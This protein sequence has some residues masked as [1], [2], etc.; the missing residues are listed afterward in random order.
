[1]KAFRGNTIDSWEFC[2][3]DGDPTDHCASGGSNAF[4]DSCI[5]RVTRNTRNILKIA[6]DPQVGFQERSIPIYL[7]SDVPFEL[8]I[9]ICCA[10]NLWFFIL[11]HTPVLSTDQRVFFPFSRFPVSFYV[12]VSI[13]IYP[14][15]NWDKSRRFFRQ[16]STDQILMNPSVLESRR[17]ASSSVE[18]MHC[19]LAIDFTESRPI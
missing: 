5:S 2:Y 15:S 3:W 7:V 11:I 9:V 16:H 14:T 10:V 19:L 13:A 1:M 18:C 4:P 6:S 12:L 8:S 17:C